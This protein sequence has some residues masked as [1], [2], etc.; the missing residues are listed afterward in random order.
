[1]RKEI[2]MAI[3]QLVKQSRETFSIYGGITN[4]AA[5]GETILIGTSSVECF[6][7]NGDSASALLQGNPSV[8]AD[9]LKLYQRIKASEGTEALSPYKFSFLMG[10]NQNNTF[11]K[12]VFLY[13]KDR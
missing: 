7:K 5:T 10:T 3:N 11:E 13:I 9:G 4:V 12:D 8:S 2:I 6:D 1:M